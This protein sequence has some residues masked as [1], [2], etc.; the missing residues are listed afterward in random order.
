MDN[1]TIYG[2]NMKVLVTPLFGI[3]D[4]LMTTP[5]IEVLKKSKPDIHLT[6]FTIKKAQYDVLKNNPYIDELIYFPLTDVSKLSGILYIL[7]N[8]SFKYDISL[9]FYPSNR[10]D[11]NLFSFL[12][13]SK[14]RIGHRYIY[15]DVKELNWL[16]NKTIK[17]DLKLHNVEENVRLLKFFDI[18]TS[19]IPEMKIYLTKEE[20]NYGNK[21][22]KNNSSTRINI[23]IHAG[24][25][26]FKNHI[27][28][29]WS[30]EKFL[31]LIKS[32]DNIANF[33][34]FG[35]KEEDDVNHF[36]YEN[37]KNV[38]WVK[39]KSIREVAAIIKNLDLFVSN[40]SGLMHLAAATGIPV[41]AIFGPT[42]PDFVRPW[43]K[44]HTVVRLD[45]PCSPCFYYS[46][47]P[48][49][50]NE[51]EEFKCIRNIPVEYVIEA[52]KKYI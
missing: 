2:V 19:D 45:L 8:I 40:D 50:C 21:F 37:S 38:I 51:E 39:D 32:F 15:D 52:I 11:Y 30:K 23:G 41:I 42:N 34:L 48:L 47:K 7:K 49:T 9:N 16:K 26:L 4:V 24:S 5:A 17:E 12:T 10:K 25:S 35:T 29:R 14:I 31:S 43:G 13:F 1:F 36:L 6:Y 27:N 20:T 3:G 44:I 28:K 18:E 22:V 46:P 33:F